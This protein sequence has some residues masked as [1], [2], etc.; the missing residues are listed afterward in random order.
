MVELRQSIVDHLTLA[1]AVILGAFNFYTLL[2]AFY[3]GKWWWFDTKAVVVV[4]VVAKPLDIDPEFDFFTFL[5]HL[6]R[7]SFD[8]TQRGTE[9]W[10][11]LKFLASQNDLTLMTR[12]TSTQDLASI[13]NLKDPM[14]STLSLSAVKLFEES[15]VLWFRL[16]FDDEN[17]VVLTTQAE[18]DTLFL[19]QGFLQ[20]CQRLKTDLEY[21]TAVDGTPGFLGVTETPNEK[22]TLVG[23]ASS[24]ISLPFAAAEGIMRVFESTDRLV[25]SQSQSQSQLQPQPQPQLQPH[26]ASA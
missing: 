7:G 17:F 26:P 16:Q 14:Y 21:R 20:L 23:V 10:R 15:E 19:A 3:F 8:V 9:Q 11:T 18:D 13:E 6:R 4:D 12:L 1:F 2:S 25:Q 5:K 24:M 22:S